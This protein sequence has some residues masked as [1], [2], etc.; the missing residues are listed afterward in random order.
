MAEGNTN[1]KASDMTDNDNDNN[2]MSAPEE[3]RTY[4]CSTQKS[5][6]A[7]LLPAKHTEVEAERPQ[8]GKANDSI[9]VGIGK[10]V[11]RWDVVKQ[12]PRQLKYFLQ[13][14]KFP[15]AKLAQDTAAAF[16]KACDTW[17]AV[18]LGVKI[19]AAP[20][21]ASANFD[22]TYW[23]PDDPNETTLAMAFFPN[24]K[25][26]TFGYT[27]ME[28]IKAFYKL[29]NGTKVGGLPVTDYIPT[30]KKR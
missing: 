1:P 18:D 6:N 5:L 12:R 7:E 13:T 3:K 19:M 15:S 23:D 26:Q 28:G 21:A 16:Q 8:M 2:N 20:D 27:D 30:I 29:K 22:L 14:S 11:P 10:E 17:N 4:T 24:E 9:V 25:N